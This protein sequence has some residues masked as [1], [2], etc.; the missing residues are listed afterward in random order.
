MATA[1]HPEYAELLEKSKGVSADEA[2]LS[3][4]EQMRIYRGWF[5]PLWRPRVVGA[6]TLGGWAITRDPDRLGRFELFHPAK[7]YIVIISGT[8]KDG[9]RW[10]HLSFSRG[11]RVPDWEELKAVKSRFLGDETLAVQV[12]PP[13]SQWVNVHP[14]CLHLWHCVDGDPLPDFREIIGPVVSI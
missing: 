8:V 11:D 13:K 4:R 14:Y 12:F 7:G 6:T 3:F 10:V 5:G 1:L 9:G 2:E